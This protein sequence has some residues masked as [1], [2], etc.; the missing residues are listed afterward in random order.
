[1]DQPQSHSVQSAEPVVP[2]SHRLVKRFAVLYGVMLLACAAL[3]AAVLLP[4]S[5]FPR[6]VALASEV[7]TGGTAAIVLAA[8]LLAFAAL[9]A[10]FALT[11]TRFNHASAATEASEGEP[12]RGDFARLLADPGFAGRQGQAAVFPICAV[13]IWLV[14]RLLWP[15]AAAST[16]STAA[17][18]AAGLICIVAFVVLVTERVMNEF[19]APQLPEAPQLRRLLLLCTLVLVGAV[20]AEVGRAAGISWIQWPARV[21][22]CLPAVVATEL[23]LRALARLFL[24]PRPAAQANAATDSLVAGLLTGGPRAPATLLRT[25]FGLDFARS[26]ALSFLAAAILPAVFG[27]ALLCWV[28]SGLK[29]IDLGQRGIYERLGAPVAVLGPGLHLLL[30]WPFGRLRPVE[31]GAIHALAVGVDQ[32]EPAAEDASVTAEQVAPVSMN[33]LWETAHPGQ[34]DYLIPSPGTGQQGF[35]IVSTEISVLYRVGLTDEAAMESVYAVSDPAAL[36][37]S[38]ANR[39]VLQYFS[40][41]TLEDVLGARRE[42][43]ADMLRDELRKELEARKTGI[44]VVSVLIEEI[45]PPAGAAQ[46]YHAV[47]AAEIN[48]NASIFDEQGKAKRTAGIAEQEAHQLTTAATA[49]A[50][51]VLHTASADAYRF[52]ADERAYAA[53][54]Q[55]FLLERSYRNLQTALS[56]APLTII[57]HRLSPEQGPVIDLRSGESAAAPSGAS[58]APGTSATPSPSFTPGIELNNR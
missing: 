9:L 14:A 1:M 53:G 10:T 18:V 37:K 48:A 7:V 57:D 46:A 8:L 22:V 44:D 30:P 24:P 42:N 5:K 52:D 40:S 36:V 25:H 41:R 38:L 6:T 23:A 28:L 17:N 21:L 49:T 51:E 15:A 34:A 13:L 19:P 39:L 29:L 3:P 32:N 35:Q 12:A 31:F 33:R 56:K 26:W 20:C 58:A 47:Q 45:H 55:A 50:T 4:A 2:R 54:G 11:L 27:T 43:V 16:S